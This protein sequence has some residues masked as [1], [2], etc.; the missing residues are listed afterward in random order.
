MNIYK[1][2]RMITL[3]LILIYVSYSQAQEITLPK[4]VRFSIGD[5]PEWVNPNFDDSHWGTQFLGK[6]WPILDVYDWYLIKIVI[7]ESLKKAAS[8]RNGLLLNLGKFDDVD[9]TFFNG[10]LV[11]ETG[12]FPPNVLTKWQENRSVLS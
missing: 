11:G 10:K 9:Q 8:K 2:L 7:P 12:S 5:N 1:T 3:F 4:E 6:S